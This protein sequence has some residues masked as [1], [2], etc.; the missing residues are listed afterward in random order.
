MRDAWVWDMYRPARF[1]KTVRV[2]TFKD[3]NI[4]ELDKPDLETAR[5]EVWIR[6]LTAHLAAEVM[7]ILA[8]NDAPRVH[9]TRGRA[10]RGGR[11]YWAGGP[12]AVWHD[13]AF[14][15]AY[16]LRAPGRQGPRL[17]QRRRPL[18]ATACTS[19]PSRP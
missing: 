4:E 12:S 8:A 17:R 19:R 11:G 9:E 6:V 13:G 1:V 14:W 18:R 7:R 3:V 2:L 16:R 5:F 10:A 15:L